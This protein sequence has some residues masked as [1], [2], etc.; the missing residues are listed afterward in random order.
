MIRE[1]MENVPRQKTTVT[2]K[3]WTSDSFSNLFHKVILSDQMARCVKN[4]RTP[5][6]KGQSLCFFC[7]SLTCNNVLVWK[8]TINVHVPGEQDRNIIVWVLVCLGESQFARQVI[9]PEDQEQKGEDDDPF[10]QVV[11]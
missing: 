9:G 11:Q 8:L 1:V 2:E 6:S 4:A 5:G 3:W 10:L 7:G